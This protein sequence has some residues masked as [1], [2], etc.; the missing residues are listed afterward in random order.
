MEDRMRNLSRIILLGLMITALAAC[1]GISDKYSEAKAENGRIVIPVSQVND[2]NA[3]YYKI[4]AAGKEIKFFVVKSTDGVIRAAFDACDVCY[5]EKK[6]YTQ[7]GE[8]M[9][10]NNC[11]QRFHTSRINIVKGGCNP[12]PLHRT[13]EGENVVITMAD[14]QSGAGYF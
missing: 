4:N 1:G 12:S 3:H 7:D 14:I 11:G 8:Y 6:G 10:C 9:I 13:T 2:G 5:K